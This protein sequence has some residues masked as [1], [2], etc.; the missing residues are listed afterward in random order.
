MNDDENVT[1]SYILNHLNK[2][3]V[4]IVVFIY[5]GVLFLVTFGAPGFLCSLFLV[6]LENPALGFAGLAFTP[7]VFERLVLRF[8]TFGGLEAMGTI[9]TG[10]KL[11]SG[12]DL[13]AWT[14]LSF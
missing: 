3:Q 1:Q 13:N 8:I 5:Y 10:G 4:S 14:S 6:G 9:P 11:L 7:V 2:K 12:Q